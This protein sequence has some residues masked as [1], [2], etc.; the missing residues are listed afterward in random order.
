MEGENA[1]II[2]KWA[3]DLF[4]GTQS[5]AKQLKKMGYQVI[6]LDKNKRSKPDIPID[7]MQWK[8]RKAFRPGD[9]ELIAASVPCNEYSQAKKVGVRKMEEADQVVLK[10]LEIIKYLKPEK[11]WIE[12]PRNGYLKF[13]GILDKYPF[14]DVDY[15]QF[16]D[17]GYQK[18]T[19]FWGSPNV[20]DREPRICDGKNCPNLMD[21]P[22]GRK[23]HR[24]RLGGEK[25]QFS[26]R[27]KGR[28]PADVVKYLLVGNGSGSDAAGQLT[29]SNIV[30]GE[31]VA[32]GTPESEIYLQSRLLRP[33]KS[34]VLNTCVTRNTKM[35]L[36]MEIPAVLPNGERKNLKMLIDTGAQANLVRVGLISSHLFVGASKILRFITANG[37]RMEGGERTVDLQLEFFREKRMKPKGKR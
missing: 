37:Q 33:N 5:V 36:I 11:W 30:G 15:C 12:N 22:M 1:R 34:Y 18:P 29:C 13:R 6:T 26:T 2:E 35:Q 27:L 3:L 17:W 31:P 9:F 19:R 7:I 4:S 20:V 8:Y 25:M 21:G 14:L 23:R 28:I 24:M 16:S 10:T 32:S